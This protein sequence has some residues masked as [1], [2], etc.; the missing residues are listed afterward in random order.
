MVSL[1]VRSRHW[2]LAAPLMVLLGA[3]ATETPYQPSEGRYGYHEQQ[4]E[5]SRYRVTFAG[6]PSTPR[7]TVQNY[8]LYRAAELTVQKGYDYFTV[9]DQDVERSTRYYSHG[10]VDDFGY[11]YRHGYRRYYR[12]SYYSS[13]AYPISEYASIADIVMAEGEK[14]ADDANA[15]DALDVLQQL[16]PLIRQDD[17]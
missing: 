10:Y 11:P 1:I 8:L 4:I 6:N 16:Q 2:L 9:V 7:E 15:Y 12:P 13:N 17:E 5:E 14:P 3:C